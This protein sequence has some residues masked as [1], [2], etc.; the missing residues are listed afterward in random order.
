MNPSHD[1][2][3][4]TLFVTMTALVSPA[5][6]TLGFRPLYPA[7]GGLQARPWT[8]RLVNHLLRTLTTWHDR[9][10]QRQRLADLN[11]HLLRDIG[12]TR[13]QALAEHDKPFWRA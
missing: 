6:H 7:S 13:A 1:I 12:I 2:E 9:H 11:D 8:K 5:H 3:P 10:R 4:G